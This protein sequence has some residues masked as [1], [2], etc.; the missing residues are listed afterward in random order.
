[1]T[2]H[3][4]FDGKIIPATSALVTADNRG[5]RY[6]DGLFETIK[7]IN[8]TIQLQQLHFERLF[9]GLKL[10]Q[11]DVPVHCTPAY[12]A[13]QILVLC[14]KNGAQKAA[15]V[16]LAVFRGNGGLYDA[17]NMRPHIVIQTWALPENYTRFNENGLVVDLYQDVQKSCD[18]LANVKS[19]NYLPYVM[20]A[21]FAKKHKL[22]DSLVLNIHKRICDATIANVFLVKDKAVITPP[23]SEGCVAGVMRAHLLQKIAEAGYTITEAPVTKE[24]IDTADEMFLT[25]ALYG[26]RWVQR[27]GE[28]QFG[29]QFSATC[30]HKFIKN[31]E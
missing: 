22:N 25:N 5:L 7:V 28:K 15:R 17:E 29:N 8:N 30:Y 19:N 26:I 13:E 16:R 27:C 4:Y 20:A 14:K 12:L 9:N 21:L 18:I 24:M 10:L 6:G 3:I 1:M 2:E 11:F 31:Q 23:L